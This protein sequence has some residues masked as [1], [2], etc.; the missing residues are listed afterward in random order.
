M[1]QTLLNNF[2]FY[3]QSSVFLTLLAAYLGGVLVSFTPC[4]YP[5][6]P[7][8][9]AYV[10]GQSHGS[11][12]KGLLLSIIYVL[13]TAVTY[14]ALGGIAAMSGLFF[15][16]IQTSPWTYFIVANICIL[17]GLAMLDVFTFPLP[18]FLSQAHTAATKKGVLGGFLL[19]IASGLVL[20]PCT[21]PVLGVLLS[22][23]AT[24][25]NVFYGM[26]LLFVFAFGMGTLLILVGTFTGLLTNLPKAGAWMIKI[27][28]TFGWLLIAIGEYFLF[29]AG[30]FSI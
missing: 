8:T 7:I 25:Q 6:I 11:K 2:D 10:G 5:V 9:V 26:S 28:K 4:I 14:T 19:G 13:G 24:K 16:Q 29:T 23:V 3:L 20:G 15:G 18:G 1:I 30:T 12:T 21:A 27:Q 17:M 22:Y